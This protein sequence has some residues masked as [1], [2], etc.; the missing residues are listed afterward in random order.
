MMGWQVGTR[1]LASFE[2]Y[3]IVAVLYVTITSV[4]SFSGR[5]IERRLS[6]P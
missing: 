2:S 1:T 5:I 3:L 4:I 6:L